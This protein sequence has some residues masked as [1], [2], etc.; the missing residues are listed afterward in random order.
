[1][2]YRK[3]FVTNSS[4]SSYVCECCGA[5]ESG[6]DIGLSEA[7]MF[8]C[9][10][11]HTLCDEELANIG[12]EKLIQ[13][14]VSEF[15]FADKD[16]ANCSEGELVETL[17]EQGDVRWGKLGEDFCPICQF[18]VYSEDDMAKYLEK[19]YGVSRDEV[20]AEIKQ[21]NKHRKKLY[22]SEYISAVCRRFNLNPI[23]IVESWKND[24]STYRDFKNYIGR[25]WEYES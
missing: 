6:W 11:G 21:L 9:T 20:L 2:K 15:N 22:N 7:G 18:S 14:L 24:F 3:D 12:K 4:S 17:L 16:I 19:K 13:K 1:M 5:T 10:N 23:K 8:Y 25:S